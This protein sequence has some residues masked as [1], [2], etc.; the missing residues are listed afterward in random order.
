MERMNLLARLCG[1]GRG[2]AFVG[3]TLFLVYRQILLKGIMLHPGFCRRTALITWNMVLGSSVPFIIIFQPNSEKGGFLFS[4]MG[5]T[6][7][8][9]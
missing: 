3:Y 1:V 4:K 9:F 6:C 7:P 5:F 2:I 8:L